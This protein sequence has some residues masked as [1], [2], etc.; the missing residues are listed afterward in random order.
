[1]YAEVIENKAEIFNE[2]FKADFEDFKNQ[3]KTTL[4]NLFK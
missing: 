3:M 4:E 1:V 2:N